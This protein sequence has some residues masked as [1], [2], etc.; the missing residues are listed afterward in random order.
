M[1]RLQEAKDLLAAT[2]GH[3]PGPYSL[4]RDNADEYTRGYNDGCTVCQQCGWE[5]Q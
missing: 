5:A 3:T 4:E 1:S 2:E